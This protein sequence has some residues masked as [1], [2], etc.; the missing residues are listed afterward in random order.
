MKKI[1]FMLVLA[2]IFLVA[3]QVY[4]VPIDLDDDNATVEFVDK[5]GDTQIW[6]Y[7]VEE[8]VLTGA[9][10]EFRV[11]TPANCGLVKHVSYT[12]L[13]PDIDMYWAFA[14]S[15]AE[16]GIQS[17]IE[18]NVNLSYGPEM[19]PLDY[20]NTETPQ[21]SAVYLNAV[22]NSATSTGATWYVRV[23]YERI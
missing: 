1:L 5:A 4:A 3:P 7:T 11:K 22:N 2:F 21:L 12:S 15:T 18:D 10:K 13:S 16:G 9:P 6:I 19:R 23:T 17:F 20:C 14:P 8:E